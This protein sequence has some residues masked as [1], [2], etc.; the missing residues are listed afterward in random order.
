[1]AS[2]IWT[3]GIFRPAAAIRSWRRAMCDDVALVKAALDGNSGADGH[4]ATEKAEALELEATAIRDGP[5]TVWTW[6]LRDSAFRRYRRRSAASAGGAARSSAGRGNRSSVRPGPRNVGARA[7][8][9]GGR[10]RA[11]RSRRTRSSASRAIVGWVGSANATYAGADARLG[12][13]DARRLRYV[14]ALRGRF[15]AKLGRCGSVGDELSAANR[16]AR[17]RYGWY[18]PRR[19]RPWCR[20]CPPA[21]R[22]SPR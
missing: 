10:L 2:P 15:R 6:S 9:R 5:A 11:G 12:N 1:M 13:A 19:P 16:R 8:R 14:D 18:G 17:P 3:T 21:L 20:A 7:A 22:R 4:L